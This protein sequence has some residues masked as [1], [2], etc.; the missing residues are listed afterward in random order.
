MIKNITTTVKWR[1]LVSKVKGKPSN[2]QNVI[3]DKLLSYISELEEQIIEL[4]DKVSK[5]EKQIDNFKGYI[6]P[7]KDNYK[8]D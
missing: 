5:L 6:F 2:E 3:N 1:N 4:N 8:E 7:F